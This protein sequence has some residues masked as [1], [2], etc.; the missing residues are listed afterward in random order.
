LATS[1]LLLEA[2][3]GKRDLAGEVV[4]VLAGALDAVR[5][6]DGGGDRPQEDA[7]PAR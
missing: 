5:V 6:Q 3:V 2:P 1:L 4:V 7:A